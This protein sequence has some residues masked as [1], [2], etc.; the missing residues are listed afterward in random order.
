MTDNGYA[1]ITGASAGIGKALAERFADQG[2]DLILVARR[3]AELE[4]LAARL[5]HEHGIDAVPLSAD[6]A[7]PDGETWAAF[8]LTSSMLPTM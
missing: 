3:Q 1:L 2:H 7:T 8:S 5:A 6:L 4:A